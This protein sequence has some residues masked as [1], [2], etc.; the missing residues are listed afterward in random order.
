MS[1]QQWGGIMQGDESYA[2]SPSFGRFEAAG[3][4]AAVR[5]LAVN[6]ILTTAV[7]FCTKFFRL[8]GTKDEI[9]QLHCDGNR[10]FGNDCF[11]A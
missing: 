9:E 8:A 2:G 11:R 6:F 10:A 1:A 3:F 5:R 7:V 4:E